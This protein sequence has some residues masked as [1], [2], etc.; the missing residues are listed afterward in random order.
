[1]LKLVH[2]NNMLEIITN[3]QLFKASDYM[4]II[5]KYQNGAAIR[6]ADVAEVTE[7]VA[8]LRNAGLSNGKPSVL[9]VIFKQ[10][11]ANII[12]TVDQVKSLLPF[13][14]SSIPQ[15]IDL[16]VMIDRTTTIRSSLHDI[17]ITL[18]LAICL[19]I[20]VVYISLSNARAALIPSVAVPLSLLGTF[21]IMYLCGYSLNNLSLMALTIATGFVVD[22][23]VVVLE[24]ISR[25]IENGMKPFVAAMQGTKEVAFTVLS[26]STSLIAVFIPIL[27]MGGIV[28][29]LFR[30]FAV[31]LS[32]AI[33]VSLVVS[34]TVTPMMCAIV[35]KPENK[36][37]APGFLQRQTIHLQNFYHKTLLWSLE[38]QVLMLALTIIAVILTIYLF[39]TVPKGFFPQQDTGRITAALQTDQ[40]M[41]FQLIEQRFKTIVSKVMQDPA[42]ENV[43][44]FVGGNSG[45]NSG[46]MYISLKPLD[47]RQV[48]ADIVINRLRQELAKISGITLYMQSS[49]ELVIGGRQGTA[50]FQY[51]LSASTLPELKLWGDRVIERLSK[52][53]G[54]V[55][56]NSD[57]RDKGLQVLVKIDYDTAAR[58]GIT[59]KQIDTVLYNAFGQKEVSTLYTAMNQYYI[60]MEVAPRYWQRPET[61]QDIYVTSSTGNQVPLSAFAKFVE[62][63]T[64]LAV[65]HQGQFPSSTLSFNLLPGFSLGDV[66]NKVEQ[67]VKTMHLPAGVQASFQGTAQAF[68]TS[69][70]SEPYLII[71]ALLAVYIVLGI[72]Y[73]SLIH[74]VTI[75]STLPS[76]SVG[77]LLAL[78]LTGTDLTIIALI[79]IILLIGIV[80]K[81][82][83]MMIDFAL[84]L[85]RSA[86]MS[87]EDAIYQAAILRFRPIMMTTMAALCSALTLALGTGVGFELRRP[88]GISIIGGLILSQALTLYTTPVI[89]LAFERYSVWYTHKINKIT[90]SWRRLCTQN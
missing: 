2:D 84:H 11:G 41:S 21:S 79:G 14:K 87:A 43:V 47:Q 53:H 57:Q 13:L 58:F 49:Q 89:Y 56:I 28:G 19:V 10:P 38:H 78:F 76:A 32:L 74:P 45:G 66:V 61:L 30:E 39:I 34:L 83:I 18:L 86:N 6:I 24:N 29:R 20:G 37:S 5:L 25:H 88:L 69:L 59:T 44:G 33:L 26:M 55:D 51:T 35:L 82:A 15:A 46:S 70:A 71:T 73:E 81:N 1:M 22:D 8:D 23:A 17:E 60:I 48:N 12:T 27:L 3:D 67:V 31:T 85:K 77:A 64:L 9:L 65:N 62:S 68:Q 63:K 42:V 16:T 90:A 4:P 7:S 40:D 52:I 80:K 54:I 72:L 36:N 50:Q 75:L